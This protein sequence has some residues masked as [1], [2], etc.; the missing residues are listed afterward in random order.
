MKNE[1]IRRAESGPFAAKGFSLIETCIVIIILSLVL[2]PLYAYLN[3]QK[4]QSE[5]LKQEA[6]NEQ[7]LAA[8]ALYVRQNG[9][10]PC[11]ANP[12]LPSNDANYGAADCALASVPGVGA[13]GPVLIGSFPVKETNLPYQLAVNRNGWQYIYAVTQN[14]TSKATF[15]GTG[16]INII[17][18]AGTPFVQ[19]PVQFALVNPGADGKGARTMDGVLSSAACGTTALDSENCNNDSTFREATYAVSSNINA[20]NYYD[21]TLSYT[22][23]RRESTLWVAQENTTGTGS[24]LNISNRNMGNVG[25]GTPT[26]TDKLHVAGGNIRV[27]SQVVGATTTGG[28]I[29]A[30]KDITSKNDI[31]AAK[32]ITAGQK[33]VSPSFYYNN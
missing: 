31:S 29:N 19:Q 5:D 6:A 8:L 7:V 33:V 16:S 1:N 32:Q 15:T 4:K 9:H 12:A 22:L 17:N 20:A 23:V 11:P 21:D 25:I 28:N 10:Y 14:L 18:A 24:E 3:T 27:Q 13:G 2:V 26:P 30:D